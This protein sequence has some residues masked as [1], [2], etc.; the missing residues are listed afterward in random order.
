MGIVRICKII[1][2]VI[3]IAA[4]AGCT[5]RAE[6]ATRSNSDITRIMLIN[7]SSSNRSVD[8]YAG[9]TLLAEGLE[10]GKSKGYVSTLGRP[11]DLKVF[12]AGAHDTPIAGTHADLAAEK[13]FTV[14]VAGSGEQSKIWVYPDDNTPAPSGK[15][16]VRFINAMP[17]ITAV[18][19]K[20]MTTETLL[21]KNISY[22]TA[23]KY[24][25]IDSGVY[26]LA[27]NLEGLS[28]PVGRMYNV[29]LKSGAVY[30]AVA[31]GNVTGGTSELIIVK[32]E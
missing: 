19:L 9:S 14:V 20:V 26:E 29:D 2:I 10:F 11:Y 6:L 17:D 12:A 27:V 18:D 24:K 13:S 32:N 1:I 22:G 4:L 30:T 5:R 8:V 25:S 21:S 28:V 3:L 7:G 31:V 15:A 23:D 16:R